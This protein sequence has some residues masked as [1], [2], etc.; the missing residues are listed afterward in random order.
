MSLWDEIWA[1]LDKYY[2][3]ATAGDQYVYLKFDGKTGMTVFSIIVGLCVGMA[4]A[5]FVMLYQR[6]HV[7][8]FV[9]RLFKKNAHT[10]D[11][12]VT[13]SELSLERDAFLKH[14]LSS[15]TSVVRKMVHIVTEKGI[16]IRNL[17]RSEITPEM[18]K[19]EWDR[20]AAAVEEKKKK[21]KAEREREY[22]RKLAEKNGEAL[23]EETLA[24]A[25][26][27]E[28]AAKEAVV[29][30]AESALPTSKASVFG[31]LR[32]EK[33]PKPDF[34]KDKFYIPEELK[35]RAGNRYEREKFGLPLAIGASVLFVVIG[36]LLVRFLPLLLGLLD[37]SLQA[38][39]G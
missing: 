12:A 24:E 30:E 39:L 15:P 5:S 8:R 26:A 7:G 31:R 2:F 21:E 19:A 13:L 34:K 11:T 20:T 38:M 10:A 33:F 29:K 3:S 36:F 14:A 4:V 6:N 18:E 27:E 35:F 23:P 25:P 32:G 17:Y 16:L 9:R 28:I 22:A 37:G 1:Y